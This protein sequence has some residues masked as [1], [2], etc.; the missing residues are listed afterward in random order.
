MKMPDE[1][2]LAEIASQR[3]HYLWARVGSDWRCPICARS[4]IELLCL[5]RK[6]VW[7][8]RHL[9][10]HHD[11][12]CEAGFAERFARS[13]IC[14]DCNLA[15]G[16][17]K[18]RLKLPAAFSFAPDEIARF[19]K[20]SPH[21][22]HELDLTTAAAIYAGLS[23]TFKHAPSCSAEPRRKDETAMERQ[24]RA[25]EREKAMGLVRRTYKVP[26]ERVPEFL[27]IVAQMRAE[28]QPAHS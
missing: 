19:I 16:L 12:G 6:G 7:H 10:L 4:R 17:A 15:D 26:V 1:T 28:A 20:P 8:C 24:R 27:Q 11:H 5:N 18:R 23:A 2:V 3:L 13:V 9:S 25:I 22:A 21:A 14:G